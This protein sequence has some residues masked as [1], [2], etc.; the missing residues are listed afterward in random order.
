VRVGAC[1]MAGFDYPAI[2][3]CADRFG[4]AVDDEAFAGLQLLE[5]WE[6][7]RQAAEQRRAAE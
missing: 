7:E 1:G 4:V 3:A 5:R 2:L 6:L